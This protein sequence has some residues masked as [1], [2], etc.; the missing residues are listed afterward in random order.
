[1]RAWMV[2]LTLMLAACGGP[3][4][5]PYAP[6]EAAG[7]VLFSNFGPDRP[8][9]LDPARSYSE[10]EI[11]FTGQIYEPP[12]QYHYL[13][14]PYTLEPLTAAEMPRVRYFD[15]DGRELPA[16]APA[17]AIAYTTYDIRIRP[18]IHYQPHPCFA[19]DAHGRPRYIPIDP[20]ELKRVRSLADFRAT[21]SREL[22]AADYVYQIKRLAN[23]R[24]NSPIYGLMSE[25]IVGLKEYGQLLE[26]VVKDLPPEAYVDLERYPLPGAQVID[27]YTYRITI[28]GKYPQ[29]I[30]WLAMPFFA[31]VPPEAERFYNQP[32]M[33]ERNLTLDWQPV[34]TGPFYLAEND[35]NRVMILRR[36]PH[37][38]DDFYPV[39]GEPGDAE[40]GL[41]VDAG[42]RLPLIDAAI[43]T[44]EKEDIPEWAKFLQGYYD[45]SGI[46]S[47]TFDQAIRIGPDGRPDLSPEMR[48]RDIR[49]NTAVRTSIWYVGFNMLDPVV[50]GTSERARKLRQALS[51]ALDYEEFISIFLN[52]RGIPAHGPLPPGIFGHR[53]GEAGMNPVVYRWQGGRAV[54][55]DL[56]EA[57]RL[58]AEAG[59]PDGREAE[60]GRPLTLF[61]DTMAS[62][63][64]AKSRLDWYRKQFA[65]LGIQLV[66]RSTDYNR[67]QDKMRKGNAQIFEWGWNADYPDPEN[68]LFLLYG[69]NRKAGAN[70]E[71]AANYENPEYD[72][73][74][75]Q[76]KNMENGPERQRVIDA[77]VDILRHDAPWIFAYHPLSYGLRHAWVGNV[78]PN[79]MAINTLKYRRVEPALRVAY[80]KQW[81]QPVWWPL[82]LLLAFVAA[83]VIPAAVAYRRRLAASARQRS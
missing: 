78:K 8:K 9:H 71:N 24:L 34:G 62:G 5:N 33:A 46:T 65:K 52:G 15:A 3:L 12:L 56:A 6:G 60:S 37:Y 69:P 48:A 68:F 59:Y 83:A 63:P 13:R 49:L 53:E 28:R 23:P 7:N 73:L 29:F 22:I 16:T 76:M 27:R 81:N 54:R 44:L 25:Y 47:D 70:G 80:Q 74:F 31:P 38:H 1:M 77:M 39:D 66:I 79:L 32:G 10:N 18:G 42:R 57:R 75:Q 35:P 20:A 19:R 41:L 21:G 45:A 55:R 51:I 26:A 40:A 61:F 4:N 43:Y 30:Y 17:E 2:W 50:G 11:V 58:L 67:F 36:N 14:R 72:R 82:G 64:E